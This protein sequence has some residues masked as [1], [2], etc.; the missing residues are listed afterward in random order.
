MKIKVFRKTGL[1]VRLEDLNSF[2]EEWK[3]IFDKAQDKC[4]PDMLRL[5]KLLARLENGLQKKYP[6]ICEWDFLKTQEDWDKVIDEYGNIMVTRSL[7][8]G[9]MLYCILDE[10]EVR[11]G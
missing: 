10:E 5:Q 6:T 1:P 4:L 7:D 2:K 9:E 3:L 8:S 11:Y